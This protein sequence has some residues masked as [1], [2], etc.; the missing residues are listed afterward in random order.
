MGS[1]WGR[2][3]EATRRHLQD[4]GTSGLRTLCLSHRDVSEVEYKKWY[5]E[6]SIANV[7]LS[8]REQ[9]LE[10]VYELIEQELNLVGCTAIEDQLQPGVPQCIELLAG[11]GIRIWMLT[12]DKLETA[13]NI[14][15]ACSLLRSRCKKKEATHKASQMISR[16]LADILTSM[17]RHK[18]SGKEY[19]MIIDGKALN[20]AL[21]PEFAD[22][23]M[24]VCNH[25]SSVI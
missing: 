8:E 6:W 17:K 22:H 21:T 7:A 13:I 11:A 14:G 19:A 9:K 1:T 15:F 18:N 5:R 12:G 24:D 16:E 2:H 25:C 10:E 20:I 4:F 3:V 23:F